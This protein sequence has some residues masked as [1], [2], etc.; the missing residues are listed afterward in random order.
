MSAENDE[1]LNMLL[2]KVMVER[3][4]QQQNNDY[5]A[6]VANYVPQHGDNSYVELSLQRRGIKLCEPYK[7]ELHKCMHDDKKQQSIMKLAA[8][9]PECKVERN[10]YMKCQK[11]QGSDGC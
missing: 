9:V 7:T 8:S 5:E 11:S 6:C 2:T 4:C 10:Q 1:A 3:F